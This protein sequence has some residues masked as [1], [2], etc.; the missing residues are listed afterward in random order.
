[1][2]IHHGVNVMSANPAATGTRR[3]APLGQRTSTSPA[4]RSDARIVTGLSTLQ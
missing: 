4:A 3:T 1:M 2:R